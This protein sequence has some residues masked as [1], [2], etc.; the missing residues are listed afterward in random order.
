MS[1][2]R[3]EPCPLCP[4]GTK[5]EGHLQLRFYKPAEEVFCETISIC[6]NHAE[7]ILGAFKAVETSRFRDPSDA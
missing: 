4:W 6:A 1:E 3:I 5:P 7:Q 2:E